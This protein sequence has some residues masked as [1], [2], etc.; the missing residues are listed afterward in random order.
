MAVSVHRVAMPVAVSRKRLSC[1]PLH[2]YIARPD[3]SV[4]SRLT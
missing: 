3:I 4:A 2:S 1:Y